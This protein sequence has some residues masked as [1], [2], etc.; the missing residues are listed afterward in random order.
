[1]Q[2]ADHWSEW[3]LYHRFGGNEAAKNAMLDYL[4]PVRDAVLA[5]ANVQAH[6]TLLDVGT[7][8]GLIAFGALQSN[9]TIRV[10]LSD[11]SDDLLQ[12]SRSLAQAI[13]V[14]ERCS[15]LNMSADDL[16]LVELS[17]VDAV[18]MRSVLIYVQQKQRAFAEFYRV[19]KPNGRLSLFEPIN[20][21]DSPQPRHLF[22]GYDITP[23]MNVMGKIK[24]LYSELQPF[25]TDPMLNF[26]ERDMLQWC[27][28]AGFDQ[29]HLQ[30]K[31]DIAQSSS[32]MNWENFINIA[33][34][35]NVPTLHDAMNQVLSSAEIEQATTYLSPLVNS[36]KAQIRSA[37]MYLQA[38][39]PMP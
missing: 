21:F 12:H 30:L 10:I 7:G 5:G 20:R 24:A 19:L 22:A 31:I 4:Y 25:D 6:E 32:L 26:D 23:I 3:I 11:I 34:N 38:V 28:A 15:F 18:T 36:R 27:E 14:L 9:P 17:T 1:M 8:D 37:V 16:S 35:P 2:H 39:K 33:P 29:V 13:N